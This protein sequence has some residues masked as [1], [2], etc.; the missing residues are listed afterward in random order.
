MLHCGDSVHPAVLETLQTQGWE[1]VAVAG[2]MDPAD[3][4]RTLPATRR[5]VLGGKRIGL[6]HGWG[7]PEGIERRVA[8]ALQDVDGVVFGHTHRPYWGRFAGL[9]L[10]NPGAACGWG[11]PAGATVGILEIS[12]QVEGQILPLRLDPR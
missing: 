12:E 6:M 3:L 4:H 5:I 7:S 10:F 8:E 11:S 2:N 1:V 9:W